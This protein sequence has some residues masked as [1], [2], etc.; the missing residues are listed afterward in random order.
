M[1]F[2][3]VFRFAASSLLAGSLG[4]GSLG[5]A[6]QQTAEMAPFSMNPRAPPRKRL[7]RSISRSSLMRP[8][9][10]MALSL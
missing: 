5:L 10:S 9:A 1:N 7:R 6:A 2:I 8:P 3:R 4:A